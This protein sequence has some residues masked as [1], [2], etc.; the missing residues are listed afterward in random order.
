MSIVLLYVFFIKHVFYKHS[1]YRNGSVRCRPSHG[2]EAQGEVRC[3]FGQQARP[4]AG[5]R[6]PPS[7]PLQTFAPRA[8]S[9]NKYDV[10]GVVGEGAYGVVLKCKNKDRLAVR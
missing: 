6:V 4:S 3:T 8:G 10:L 7:V 9:M 2:E 1:F 5:T